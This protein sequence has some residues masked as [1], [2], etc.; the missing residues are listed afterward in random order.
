[1]CDLI[2]FAEVIA[3]GFLGKAI[4]KKRGWNEVLGVVLGLTVG[5][6][7]TITINALILV[8][9]KWLSQ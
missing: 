3:F 9:P 1:M 7:L 6:P 8:I 2:F 4:A 5:Y